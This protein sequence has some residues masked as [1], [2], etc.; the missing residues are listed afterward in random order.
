MR[1]ISLFCVFIGIELG[2]GGF[3]LGGQPSQQAN[4]DPFVVSP[5]SSSP[6]GKY[7][8]V[9]YVSLCCVKRAGEA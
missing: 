9:L 8:L 4:K 2:F 6:T 1:V 7:L 3:G 5:S